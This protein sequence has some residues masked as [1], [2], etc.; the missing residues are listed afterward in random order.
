MR[1]QFALVISRQRAAG[2]NGVDL[3]LRESNFKGVA[4][5]SGPRVVSAPE[6]RH[7]QGDDL[8][9]AGGQGAVGD[10]GSCVLDVLHQ[11]GIADKPRMARHAACRW[12]WMRRARRA[13]HR[14]SRRA[15]EWKCVSCISPVFILPSSPIYRSSIMT[16]ITT[17]AITAR[18]SSPIAHVT[19]FRLVQ[20]SA[21]HPYVEKI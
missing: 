19:L 5:L 12:P 4:A 6:P 16:S 18:K 9:F 13:V 7:G 15:S 17:V 21:S 20:L 3:L 2:V 10:T 8:L 11:L 1:E 14:S